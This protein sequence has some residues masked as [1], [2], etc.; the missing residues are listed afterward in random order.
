MTLDAYQTA[1]ACI[2]AHQAATTTNAAAT[3]AANKLKIVADSGSLGTA[4]NNQLHFLASYDGTVAS[5]GT[6][7]THLQLQ[8]DTN[9][10][11]A[12]T[13]LSAIIAI[14]FHGDVTANLTSASFTY[15]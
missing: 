12:S 5:G 3:L 4:T 10:T 9:A 8:Y 2:I 7:T 6:D 15:I 13:T 14:D 11:T 1:F